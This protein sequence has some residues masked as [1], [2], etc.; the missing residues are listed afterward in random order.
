MLAGCATSVS[1]VELERSDQEISGNRGYL[2][3]TPPP[4][5]EVR[6]Q[7]PWQLIEIEVDVGPM[8]KP[9]DKQIQ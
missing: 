9:S 6:Q 2:M 4:E 7:K 5:Y 8:E 1:Y 3:G